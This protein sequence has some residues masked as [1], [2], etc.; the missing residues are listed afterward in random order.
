MG[1]ADALSH[2][3]LVCL[4]G[5]FLPGILKDPT[6]R[7]MAGQGLGQCRPCVYPR[8]GPEHRHSDPAELKV[9]LVLRVSAADPGG[10]SGENGM[11]VYF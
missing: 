3:F 8:I 2:L 9:P 6:G 1:C 7:T 11:L 5:P 10:D 4:L